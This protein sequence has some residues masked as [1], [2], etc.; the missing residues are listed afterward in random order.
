VTYLRATDE[1][2]F[3]IR[4][5]VDQETRVPLA[6]L[7]AALLLVGLA[8]LGEERRIDAAQRDASGSVRELAALAPRLAQV[9]ALAADVVRL[10]ALDARAGELRRSGERAA[11]RVAALGDRLPNDAWLSAIRVEGR[12]VALEGRGTRLASVGSTLATVQHVA[13]Y[14]GARLISVRRDPARSGVTYAIA[15][16]STR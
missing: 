5:R 12:A 9:R 15:V 11:A 13:G 2:L 4:I 7:G 6:A 10:R 14:G 1:R 16:E 8:G 3:G